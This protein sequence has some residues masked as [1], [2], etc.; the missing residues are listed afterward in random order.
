MPSSK[1]PL[2]KTGTCTDCSFVSMTSSGF[3]S[4]HRSFAAWPVAE[5]TAPE[6][7]LIPR[8]FF[9]FLQ[10]SAVLSTFTLQTTKIVVLQEAH[11]YLLKL[12]YILNYIY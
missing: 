6:Q 3:P 2:A 12:E 5:S 4:P 11:I 1:K 8:K 10:I 9:H 7:P